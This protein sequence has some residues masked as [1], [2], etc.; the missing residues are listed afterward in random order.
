MAVVPLTAQAKTFAGLTPNFTAA[1]G[2]GAGNGFVFDNPD[3]KSDFRIKNAS[4]S[5]ITATI[6]GAGPD[7]KP[8]TDR[9]A[10]ALADVQAMAAALT[11]Y[12]MAA[13]GDPEQLYKV[14]LGSV[15][16][17]LAVGDLMIGWRLIHAAGIAHA[18]LDGATERDQ[19]F[20]TGK[21]AVAKFFAKNMLPL[22][23]AV[24]EV[25][26]TLDVDVMELETGSLLRVLSWM[27]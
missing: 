17:L 10:T 7:L 23:S 27:D 24:R 4:G 19:A 15:R 13:Q 11:G 9:L 6:D 1:G 12:L 26:E 2:I 14:G 8:E 21:I 5:Q 22:L 25:I 3:G 20:Y 18:A 16:F